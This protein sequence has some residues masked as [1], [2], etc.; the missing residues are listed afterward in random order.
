M[1][2]RG[3]SCPLAYQYQPEVLA[4]P[5]Q[6]EAD[7]LYEEFLAIHRTLTAGAIEHHPYWDVVTVIDLVGIIDPD[8]PLPSSDLAALEAYVATALAHL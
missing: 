6:L 3:R 1:D 8:D 7:T 2:P 5:A 4:Q